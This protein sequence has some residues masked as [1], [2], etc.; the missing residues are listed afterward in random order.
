MLY[1]LLF[2]GIVKALQMYQ[3]ELIRHQVKIFV[4]RGGPNYQEG[5][6][7]MRDLGRCAF[8]KCQYSDEDVHSFS[9]SYFCPLYPGLNSVVQTK[10]FMSN[11]RARKYCF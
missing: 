9:F 2:Q 8:N 3:Q 7:I 1:L 11:T 4:R 5:L 10:L 6:R